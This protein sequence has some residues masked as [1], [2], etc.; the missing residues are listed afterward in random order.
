MVYKIGEGV[1]SSFTPKPIFEVVLTQ[2]TKCLAMQGGGRGAGGGGGGS[3]TVLPVINDLSLSPYSTS[4][5]LTCIKFA[6]RKK[7]TGSLKLG[8]ANMAEKH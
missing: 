7:K 1:K 4:R 8:F 3:Q 2:Y 5:V 6:R